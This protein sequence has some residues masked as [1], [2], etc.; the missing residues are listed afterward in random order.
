VNK[1]DQ[2]RTADGTAEQA[3]DG[4][5]ERTAADGTAG[6]TE[7]AATAEAG[8]GPAA[9]GGHGA[10]RAPTAAAAAAS[11]ARRIGG[12]AVPQSAQRH[13]G[14][15][16]TRPAGG[17]ADDHPAGTQPSAAGPP[18]AEEKPARRLSL[19]K[20]ATAPAGDGTAAG[21]VAGGATG[22]A[23]GDDRRADR[24]VAAPGRAERAPATS[25]GGRTG[26]SPAVWLP[27]ALLGLAAAAMVVVLVVSLVGG[28]K[29]SASAIRDRV[30]AAAKTC[31][32]ASNSYSYKHLDAFEK[33]GLA[34]GTGQFAVQFKQS[35]EKV[36]KKN[37]PSVKQ[38]QTFQANEA[39]IIDV[40]AH[41]AWDVMVYGQVHVVNV[42]TGKDGRTDPYGA[43]ARLVEVH[44]KWRIASLDTLCSQ[45]LLASGNK[46]K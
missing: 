43:I 25:T 17:P 2:G 13:A 10:G 21:T 34:C 28:H 1:P 19:R 45:T 6:S 23:A 20:R 36:L 8:S 9:P 22:R 18:S 44:G 14:E 38:T 15:R 16:S 42:G 32:A 35:V 26:S 11:R 41:D 40:T 5:A 37:A 7:R 24:S 4:T 3:A 30:L 46:C 39:G 29:A 31:L 33:K 27:A 12:R